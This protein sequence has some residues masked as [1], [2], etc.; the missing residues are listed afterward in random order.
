MFQLAFLDSPQKMEIILYT[1]LLRYLNRVELMALV[2]KDGVVDV[3]DFI[4]LTKAIEPSDFL[5]HLR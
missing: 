3:G 1:K 4:R 2:A 5:H